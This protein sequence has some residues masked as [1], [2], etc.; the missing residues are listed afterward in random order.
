[1][2]PARPLVERSTRCVMMAAL[3]SGNHKADVVANALAVAIQRL[4]SHLAKR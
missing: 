2:S 4:P 1:M 3:P